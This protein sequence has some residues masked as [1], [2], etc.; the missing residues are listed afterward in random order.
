MALAAAVVAVPM[1]LEVATVVVR[2]PL[3]LLMLLL[4]AG[5]AILNGTPGEG[6]SGT[7]PAWAATTTTA[8]GVA[9]SRERPRTAARGG[10]NLA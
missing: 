3:L 9:A 8:N 7:Q 6:G 1:L 5:S 4:L 2:M 10:T